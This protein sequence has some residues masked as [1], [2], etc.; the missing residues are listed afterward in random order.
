[1]NI[2]ICSLSDCRS[3]PRPNR[4]IEFFKSDHKVTFLGYGETDDPAVAMIKVRRSR[5]GITSRVKD[6]F[7][8]K[9]GKYQ[10]YLRFD[11]EDTVRQRILDQHFDL[12]LCHDLYLLPLIV[13]AKNSAKL[14]FDAREY[15]PRHF[16][17]AI[18]W[19][20]ML[21]KLN[22]SLCKTHLPRCDHAFTVSAG[23]ANAYQR[24]F[25]IKMDILYSLPRPENLRPTPVNPSRLKII[26][27]GYANPAREIESMIRTMDYLDD[28]FTLDLIL[29]KNSARYFKKLK[30][31]AS[32]RNNVRI[33]APV[34]FREIVKKLNAYDIGFFLCPPNTF[35]LKH[36]MPNKLFEFVQARLAVA[37]GPSPDMSAFVEANRVGVVAGDFSPE[38]MARAI[39]GL[40]GADIMQLKNHAHRAAHDYNA[41]RN[42][43]TLRALAE[44][45]A[46]P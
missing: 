45:L 28:R 46:A 33:I 35:N 2:L 7:Y 37:V 19:R 39:N 18:L 1:M 36:A 6:I 34:P 44:R 14:I 42:D 26:H 29:V 8:L 13:S 5:F 3:D 31:M 11:D 41:T 38:S 21:Q 23:L 22:I 25:K 9:A 4:A 20:F 32:Q 40:T 17:N 27:H 30:N 12:I 16:E 43:N 24:K 10:N 15:Y